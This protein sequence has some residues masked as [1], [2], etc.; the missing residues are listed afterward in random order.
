MM[1]HQLLL[2]GKVG[3]LVRGFDILETE[4]MDVLKQCMKINK[5][6]I[7]SRMPLRFAVSEKQ[8]DPC[9]SL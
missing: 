9:E 5:T 7:I 1:Y 2:G 4:R 8:L 6:N 3:G